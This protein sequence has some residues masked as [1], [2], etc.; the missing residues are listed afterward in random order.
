MIVQPYI[1]LRQFPTMKKH[2]IASLLTMLFLQLHV[3]AQQ[4]N[5]QL[6]STAGGFIQSA[7]GSVSFSIGEPVIGTITGGGYIVNQGFQQPE[8]ASC[9]ITG[10]NPFAASVYSKLDSFKLDA[11]AGYTRYRWST[12]DSSQSLQA[13][14]TGI[15]HVTVTNASGCTGS[16]T[17][18]IQFPDT[19]GLHVSTVAGLCNKSLDVPVRATTFRHLLTLQGSVNW[20]ASDLRFDS[21]ASYGATALKMD[22]ANFGVSQTSNGKLTF[23]WNDANSTGLTLA[24]TAVLFTMRFTVLGNTIRSVPITISGTPTALESYDA[25]LVKKTINTTAGAVNVTCEFTITGKVLT[26]LNHGVR[27]VTVTLTGGTSPLTATT[28]SSGNYSFKILPGTYTLSPVKTYEKNKTNGISTLDVALIQ[29]HILQRTPFN[30]AYKVIAGDVNNSSGVTTGDILF[31]RKLI[32][33]TDT[34]LPDNRIWAFVDGDQTFA[35]PLVPFPFSSTKTLT[36]QST[37]ITHTFR[38]IKMG[39]VNYDR[40]PLLDQ[41]PSGDTLR[42]FGE[43]TDTE[44]G[45]ATLRVKSR[46]VNGLMGWQSTLRWDAKQLQLQSV[47]GRMTNLG[48]GE[49]WKDEGFITLSWND[50]MAEGLNITEGVEWMELRFRKTDRLQ[51]AGLGITEEK[52]YTEAFNKYYQSMGVKLEPVEL[53]GSMWNGMLRVYPNPATTM[54]NVEW[55]MEK[56][57]AAT[58]RLLDAQGRVVH[59]QRGDYGAGVQR[60][61]IR[62]S[63]GWSVAGTWMV[64]VECDGTVRNVPVLL[65]GE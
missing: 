16:D 59:V 42:L 46:A 34:T 30:A 40:N 32:L 29:A 8:Q 18:S 12:G 53:R 21:I 28:D 15:Y 25:G 10:F 22:I 19:L 31:L 2:I 60:V 11:G 35:N 61:S 55:K 1:Y 9:T 45:Y 64:Q 44:D 7:Q 23:S 20:S 37:D 50:P 26:P 63:L 33:G 54:M 24:D 4:N 51:R 43:W 52:L 27:N 58:V 47:Q 57:G 41:A 48:I 49:R 62:R 39:D 6:V 65:G 17:V 14:Y 38:G 56:A 5:L 13:K 3:R 36:N